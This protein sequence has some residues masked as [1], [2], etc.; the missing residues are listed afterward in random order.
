MPMMKPLGARVELLYRT[1]IQMLVLGR[2]SFDNY[3]QRVPTPHSKVA[4]V[5]ARLRAL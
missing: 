3:C 2:V 5:R 1:L 4:R